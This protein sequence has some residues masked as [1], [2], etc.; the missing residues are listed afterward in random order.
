MPRD[1]ARVLADIS[2]THK[3][4]DVGNRTFLV[5]DLALLLSLVPGPLKVNEI[6][7]ALGVPV[8]T[9]SKRLARLEK[10]QRLV[11]VAPALKDK[12][13]SLVHLTPKAW[14]LLRSARR[15]PA[16]LFPERE[17]A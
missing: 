8:A 16:W 13:V 14:V 10:V 17:E 4:M 2:P 3:T 15:P 9:V 7:N 12:R 6:V 5:V 1:L 11:T